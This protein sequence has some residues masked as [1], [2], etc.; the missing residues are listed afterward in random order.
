MAQELLKKLGV[1]P[2]C[3]L[4]LLNAPPGYL[5]SLGAL[6]EGASLV[7]DIAE[8]ADLLQIFVAKMSDL[9]RELPGLR[10]RLAPAG[11]LWISYPKGTGKAPDG[12]HRD[13]LREYAEQRGLKAVSMIAIDEVWSALRLKAV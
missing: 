4:L 12:L 11:A 8:S 2:G 1:R 9:E 5:E 6:P 3:R 10:A 7:S 13:R